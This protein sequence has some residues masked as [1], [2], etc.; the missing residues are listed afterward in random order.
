VAAEAM[1]QEDTLEEADLMQADEPDAPERD[2]W[3][4][5]HQVL[6]LQED[7]ANEKPM[8]QHYLEG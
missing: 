1:G 5:M 6:S 3:C 4:C 7:F 2:A 8:L